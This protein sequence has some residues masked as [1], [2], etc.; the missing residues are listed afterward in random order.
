MIAVAALLAWCCLS[1]TNG[2][3]TP[4][5]EPN[6][7]LFDSVVMEVQPLSV[8]GQQRLKTKLA[9]PQSTRGNVPPELNFEEAYVTLACGDDYALGT[10]ALIHSLQQANVTRPVI[11]LIGL[12]PE[13][14]PT[15]REELLVL[16]N[17]LGAHLLLVE[18]IV[19]WQP[20][21]VTRA[22]W[23][24]FTR[25]C[26]T[27]LRVWQL[28]WLKK[29]VWIDSDAIVM[30]NIDS[31]FERA[32]KI[33]FAGHNTGVFV[34]SPS[35]QLWDEL[36][37]WFS[38]CEARNGCL[39]NSEQCL[40]LEYFEQVRGRLDSTFNAEP[41]VCRLVSHCL[42]V[43]VLHFTAGHKPWDTLAPDDTIPGLPRENLD[44][45]HGVWEEVF[46][47]AMA[48][49]FEGDDDRHVTAYRLDDVIDAYVN[50]TTAAKVTV[51]GG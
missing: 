45:F 51:V 42:D 30:R 49:V 4:E 37:Q 15:L 7:L 3:I 41:R 33:S 6:L 24:H 36:I 21:L 27:K 26:W 38:E 17:R 39:W 25:C 13:G 50:G 34:T 23:A 8:A 14:L 44:E 5:N 18:N 22:Y 47:A 1:A 35:F 48:R 10:I 20:T 19:P 9:T 11:V 12:T 32:E 31:L 2:R 46:Q 29:V 16:L 28:S 43:H 40:L